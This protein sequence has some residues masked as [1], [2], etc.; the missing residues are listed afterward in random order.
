MY[1]FEEMA[2]LSAIDSEME[3]LEVLEQFCSAGEVDYDG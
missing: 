2:I 3:Y 1:G